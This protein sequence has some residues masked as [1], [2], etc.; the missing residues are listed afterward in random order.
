MYR[1]IANM[2]CDVSVA[3]ARARAVPVNVTSAGSL[4][5]YATVSMLELIYALNSGP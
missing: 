5:I 1:R 3:V 4:L 2:Y